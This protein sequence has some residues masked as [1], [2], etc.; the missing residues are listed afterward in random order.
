MSGRDTTERDEAMRDL[1]Q[2]AQQDS[3][4]RA[5]LTDDPKSVLERELGIDLPDAADVRVVEEAPNQIHLILPTQGGELS[6]EEMDEV[7]AGL[8]YLSTFRSWYPSFTVAIYT[9]T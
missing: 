9:D 1:M 2:R 6:E 7:A 5:E 4:F 8:S 3:V